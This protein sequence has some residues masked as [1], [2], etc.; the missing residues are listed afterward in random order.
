[1]STFP[2]A[3]GAATCR[4]RR[5]RRG[6]SRRRGKRE[7][8]LKKAGRRAGV[9]WVGFHSFH[10]TC[11]T[12]LFRSGLNAKQVQVW[13]GH[14]SPAFTLGTYVHLLSDDLPDAGFLDALTGPESGPGGNNGATSSTETSRDV[15]DTPDTEKASEQV[16]DLVPA[17][18]A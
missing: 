6:R 2:G 14:H 7:G 8:V 5:A 16:I 10:H 4:P 18:A 17:R 15:P 3:T 13:L 1:M 11:A 12:M 9:P